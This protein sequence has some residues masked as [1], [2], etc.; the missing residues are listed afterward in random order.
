MADYGG[1]I[2][3]KKLRLASFEFNHACIKKLE[4]K[5]RQ[6]YYGWDK[7]ENKTN[8][9]SL[10]Q[11]HKNRPLTQRNLIDIANFCM[12]LWNLFEVQNK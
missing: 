12:F 11:E 4:A 6:G 10:F 3:R 1:D 5:Q 8:L 9:E 2:E 7:V